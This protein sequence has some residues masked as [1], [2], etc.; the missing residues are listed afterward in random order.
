MVWDWKVIF[1]FGKCSFKIDI[2]I[3]LKY[4]GSFV[5]IGLGVVFVNWEKLNSFGGCGGLRLIFVIKILGWDIIL[6]L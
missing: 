3:L 1:K 4:I 2:F 6:K 5:S